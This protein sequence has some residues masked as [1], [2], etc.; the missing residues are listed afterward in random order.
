MVKSQKVNFYTSLAFKQLS[1]LFNIIEQNTLSQGLCVPSLNTTFF[2]MDVNVHVNE[3]YNR[4]LHD[5]C[6]MSAHPLVHCFMAVGHSGVVEFEELTQFQQY[7]N[8]QVWDHLYSRKH[9][10]SDCWRW[11]KLIGGREVS[12]CYGMLEQLQWYFLPYHACVQKLLEVNMKA[13]LATTMI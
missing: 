8:G 2:H 11:W 13:N 7:G 5:E 12:W 4:Y 3:V 1:V 9:V 10:Q 6:I